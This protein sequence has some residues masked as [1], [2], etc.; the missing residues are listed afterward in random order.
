MLD[1][2]VRTV[3]NRHQTHDQGLNCLFVYIV[4]QAPGGLFCSIR[5]GAVRPGRK[6]VLKFD[7]VGMFLITLVLFG[8]DLFKP[9]RLFSATFVFIVAEL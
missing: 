1:F 3:K 9:F 4:I 5:R 2:K 6:L 8:K 7:S